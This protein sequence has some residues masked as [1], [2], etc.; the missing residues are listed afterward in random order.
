[1]SY[2]YFKL[3]YTSINQSQPLNVFISQNNLSHSSFLNNNLKLSFICF[4]SNNLIHLWLL[5]F[6]MLWLL[7]HHNINQIF[8]RH[9]I[10]IPPLTLRQE[11][12]GSHRKLGPITNNFTLV[13]VNY[14]TCI[15]PHLCTE[16]LIYISAL[17]KLRESAELMAVKRNCKLF[18]I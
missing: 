15:M 5:Y 1:M 16:L 7:P 12:T 4:R 3:Y 10:K 13:F 14:E 18:L 11:V 9:N 2:I 8:K 17:S 6:T